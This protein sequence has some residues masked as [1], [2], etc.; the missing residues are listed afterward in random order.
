VRP[1]RA[2]ALY[3]LAVFGLG[4]VLGAIRELVLVPRLGAPMA[5]LVEAPLVLGFAWF[6][7][8]WL[9]RRHAV[10][11][12]TPRRVMAAAALILV[13][14]VEFAAGHFLRGWDLTAW[15]AHL[16]TPAGWLSLALYG[17]FALWPALQRQPR[18]GK[19]L[20]REA[21]AEAQLLQHGGDARRAALAGGRAGHLQ[22]LPQQLADTG[23][24]AA[25]EAP[26]QRAKLR[27]DRLAQRAPLGQGGDPLPGQPLR[28]GQPGEARAEVAARPRQVLA[29]QQQR[30]RQDQPTPHAASASRMC[31]GT[32][33][34]ASTGTASG[35]NSARANSSIAPCAPSGRR[36]S[37]D[38]PGSARPDGPCAPAAGG[39]ARC[40]A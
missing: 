2:A 27:Q 1:V 29:H 8:R 35:R 28:L 32:G 40:A 19:T 34:V 38:R 7:A 11:P 33:A 5:V 31:G 16:A 21:Q 39:C 6:V 23:A 14:V 12:G 20:T 22:R 18:R 13:L 36:R 4:L 37:A 26:R 30:Q 15:R 10:P 25:A 9:V 17:L 24:A 3:V